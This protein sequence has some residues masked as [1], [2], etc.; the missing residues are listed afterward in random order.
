MRIVKEYREQPIGSG[1]YTFVQWD[2]GQ[3]LIVKANPD[4]YGDQPYFKKLTFL[5][6]E[7]D[8]A[9]PLQKQGELILYLFQLPLLCKMWQVWT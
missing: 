1:P 8:A 9:L 3:Q 4:Y 5:F 2:K 6:L 7:E